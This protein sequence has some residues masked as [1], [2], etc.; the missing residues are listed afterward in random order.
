MFYPY[1]HFWKRLLGIAGG[2][3]RSLMRSGQ[4]LDPRKTPT[5]FL[6]GRDK[7]CYF[8]DE[9]Q[10]AVLEGTGQVYAGLP[11]GHWFYYYESRLAALKYICD[12]LRL[13]YEIGLKKIKQVGLAK[14]AL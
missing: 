11:G 13:P 8:H 5:L 6:Y 3:F 4:G 12:F 2:S 14:A 9:K 1:A 7:N 10:L